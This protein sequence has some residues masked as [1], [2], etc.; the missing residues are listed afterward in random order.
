MFF[1]TLRVLYFY[2]TTSEVLAW[3]SVV[4]KTLR[5]YHSLKFWGIII[6]IIIIKC[7]FINVSD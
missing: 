5:Y 1:P 6:I 2:I 3:S 7:T 4:V